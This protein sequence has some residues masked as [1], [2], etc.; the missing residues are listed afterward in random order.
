MKRGGK[1]RT[2]LIWL[3]KATWR[4]N[5]PVL[6]QNAKKITSLWICGSQREEKA[7]E[8]IKDKGGPVYTKRCTQW[9]NNYNGQDIVWIQEASRK[10]EQ[11][12]KDC[13]TRW[14]KHRAFEAEIA[15]GTI[16]NIR[17]TLLIVTSTSTLDEFFGNDLSKNYFKEVVN[18]KKRKQYEYREDVL[19]R[20]YKRIR[21]QEK[22][23]KYTQSLEKAGVKIDPITAEVLQQESTTESESSS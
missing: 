21:T 1:N 10:V 5:V 7:Q 22:V 23:R 11:H 15:Y 4:V 13:M 17:P 2:N 14:A 6:E 19:Q 16:S 18:N 9:W 3:G 12:V 8:I 20:E